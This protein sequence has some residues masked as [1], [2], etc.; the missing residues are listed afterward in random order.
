MLEHPLPMRDLAGAEP[1]GVGA[2]QA[3][4]MRFEA[5]VGPALAARTRAAERKAN[6]HEDD[7]IAT[8]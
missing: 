7:C 8:P 4:W 2:V 3:G 1:P 5:H 6:D